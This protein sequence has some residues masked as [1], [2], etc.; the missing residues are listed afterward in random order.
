MRDA[1]GT[2]PGQ[3]NEQVVLPGDR[4]VRP[5]HARSPRH[6]DRADRGRHVLAQ[7]HE[8]DEDARRARHPHHV[9]RRPEGLPRSDRER[10]P[11]GHGPDLHRP[12]D[13]ELA[14]LRE[15]QGPQGRRE[16]LEA[17]LHRSQPRRRRG[18]ARGLRSQ[19]EP[20]LRD[21]LRVL[22]RQL[23]A[24]RAVPRLPARGP[25]RDLH[26]QPD[27]GAE[28]EPQEA[29]AVP[30]PF[31]QRRSRHQDPLLALRR[32]EKK[33]ERSLWNWSVVLGQFAVFFQGRIPAL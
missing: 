32:L 14:A 31:P 9:L 17:D 11:A 10:V 16:G 7:G 12:H 19:V 28:L 6:V 30:R 4:R 23:G 2:P 26:D 5:R 29:A 13:P 18:G 3:P 22:A 21:D 25:A 27:R 20:P 1:A 33:W 24:R 15:L 8:R